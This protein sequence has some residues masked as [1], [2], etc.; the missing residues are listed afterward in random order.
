MP[1]SAASSIAAMIR[2]VRETSWASGEK[3]LVRELD[4]AGVDAP[5]ALES[6]D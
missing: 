5:L 6:E 3:T 2:R 1:A 4:L